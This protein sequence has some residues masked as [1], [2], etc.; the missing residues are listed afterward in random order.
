MG[1]LPDMQGA[2][3]MLGCISAIA[4][5]AIIEGALWILSHVTIGWAP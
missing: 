4:G 1:R 3:I 5:W 2:F